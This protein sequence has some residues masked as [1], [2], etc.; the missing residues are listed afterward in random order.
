[1][2]N[3]LAS[4]TITAGHA[5][6]LLSVNDTTDQRILFGRI[7]GSG[8]SVREAEQQ[9]ADLNNGGRVS[10][11]AVPVKKEPPKDPDI[12]DLEQRF[13]EV[14]G[15]KVSLKGTLDKGSLV[16]EYFSKDDLD[17]L[18]DIIFKE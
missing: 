17:R 8:L 11:A 7:T 12:A 5:R 3:A 9:A 6:A 4:G 15:T 16:I 13:M 2:Q 10:V 14:F 18:Y 1:M